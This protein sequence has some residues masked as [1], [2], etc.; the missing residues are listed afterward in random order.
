MNKLI[1]RFNSRTVQSAVLGLGLAGAAM[2]SQAS[3]D[4]TATTAL[5]GEAATAVLA[6]GVAVIAVK[7]GVRVYKWAA[8]AL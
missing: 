3:L 5:I 8:S 6:I 2:S 7:V 4:L 1:K